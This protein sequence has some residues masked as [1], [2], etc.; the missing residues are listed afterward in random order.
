MQG[1]WEYNWI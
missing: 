1:T